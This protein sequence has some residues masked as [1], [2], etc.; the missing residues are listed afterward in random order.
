[1]GFDFKIEAKQM[2]H[3]HYGRYSGLLFLN[4]LLSVFS[5]FAPFIIMLLY[6]QTSD[7]FT[8]LYESI[9]IILGVIL[10]MGLVFLQKLYRAHL[11]CRFSEDTENGLWKATFRLI[12]ADFLLL[13]AKTVF[14]TLFFAPCLLCVSLMFVLS[15]IGQLYANGLLALSVAAALLFVFGS[16]M[17]AV[18][19][20]FFSAV[21]YC[22]AVYADIS[23]G[24]LFLLALKACDGLLIK[25]IIFRV[26]MLGWR[27][28]TLIPFAAFYTVPYLFFG[29]L[30]LD[31]TVCERMVDLCNE[32]EE[33]SR[34]KIYAGKGRPAKSIP[35]Y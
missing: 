30:N 8:I 12:G 5:L 3:G 1:M 29:S 23:I 34:I 27:M 28:L 18:A 4:A 22:A 2:I 33:V 35:E 20:G 14:S 24:R 32:S 16:L 13:V 19:Q 11:Y 31:K 26:S 25:I 17:R 9:F 15:E 10:C 6:L 7:S 21:R